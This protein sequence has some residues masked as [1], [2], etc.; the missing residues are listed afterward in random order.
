MRV[1]RRDSATLASKR[2]QG[3]M[4][5]ISSSTASISWNVVCRK[6]I[7]PREARGIAWRTHLEI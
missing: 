4:E 5:H 1:L 3:S 2:P 7:Q 6:P